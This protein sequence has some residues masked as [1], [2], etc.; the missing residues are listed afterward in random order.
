MGGRDLFGTNPRALKDGIA[1]PHTTQAI[2]G[3]ED[4]FKPPVSGISKETINL[5]QYGRSY[6][7]RVPSKSRACSIADSAEDAV[8]I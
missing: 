3:P 8:N 4:L 1:T 6:E 5:S 7:L 2:N